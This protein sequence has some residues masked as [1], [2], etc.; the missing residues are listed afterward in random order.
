MIRRSVD[1]PDPEGPTIATNSPEDASKETFSRTVSGPVGSSYSFV[2]PRTA[3]DRRVLPRASGAESPEVTAAVS[4][5]DSEFYGSVGVKSPPDEPIEEADH[6]D[7]RHE[8]PDEEARVPGD[9]RANEELT[10]PGRLVHP[11]AVGHVFGK[12]QRVPSA[13][14]AGDAAGD[15]RRRHRGEDRD[16]RPPPKGK[17]ESA[18]HLLHLS[19]NLAGA[20]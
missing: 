4:S 5:I 11:V 13:S 18:G 8:R 12:D 3:S 7:H 20:R 2:T 9:R 10:D 15:E 16:A 14:P 17:A 1:L 19:R 6:D